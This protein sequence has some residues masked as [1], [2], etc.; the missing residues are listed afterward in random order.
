[1]N[2]YF[3]FIVIFLVVVLCPNLYA[4]DSFDAAKAIY[5]F[6]NALKKG[7]VR[8]IK[9]YIDDDL[10]QKKRVLFEENKK[11]PE[12]LRTFYKDAEFQI[13]RSRQLAERDA[14][15]DVRIVFPDSRS[16]QV[17][18]KMKKEEE[19]SNDV[20]GNI[21]WKIASTGNEVDE[22]R[23]DYSPLKRPE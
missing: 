23:H 19:F 6:F 4:D 8:S 10:Y 11:Y 17:N 12:F 16:E 15:V 3:N 9:K 14:S 22:R 20:Q 13:I 1:M 21:P 18:I 5:P 7:D 2:R